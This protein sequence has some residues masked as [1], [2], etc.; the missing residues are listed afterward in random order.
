MESE[1]YD[2]IMIDEKC[3]PLSWGCCI[4]S[5]EISLCSFYAKDKEELGFIKAKLKEKAIDF[6]TKD[7]D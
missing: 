5:D 4:Y 2:Y 7:F 3:Y 6:A 1:G